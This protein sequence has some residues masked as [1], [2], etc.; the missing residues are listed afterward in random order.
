M[1]GEAD[2]IAPSEPVNAD[3]VSSGAPSGNHEANGNNAE[4]L[5][6]EKR[7]RSGSQDVEMS[8]SPVKR[9]KGVAPIKSEYV[10]SHDPSSAC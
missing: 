1:A 5:S 6:G 8:N 7:M 3:T 2:A 4:L 10:Q 9:Q